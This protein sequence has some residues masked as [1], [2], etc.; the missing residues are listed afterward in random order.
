MRWF[1]AL[2]WSIILS[3]CLAFMVA[4]VFLVLA[5]VL[6]SLFFEEIRNTGLLNVWEFWDAMTLW[7]LECW[8]SG[9]WNA[10]N[11]SFTGDRRGLEAR[12]KSADNERLV[13]VG[14]VFELFFI[15]SVRGVLTLFSLSW[16]RL[17][18]GE[19]TCVFVVLPGKRWR[20]GS[21]ENFVEIRFRTWLLLDAVRSSMSEL[22][23]FGAH[24]PWYPN[25]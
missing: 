19:L 6:P 1:I 12:F 5:F 4:V 18:H 11:S 14:F 2:I 9:N 8:P 25:L 16:V 3:I 20:I 13:V 7:E 17:V 24:N 22:V 10:G 15:V 23:F 21:L